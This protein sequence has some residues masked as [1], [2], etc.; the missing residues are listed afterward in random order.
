MTTGLLAALISG[1]TATALLAEEA[2]VFHSWSSEAEVA[3]LNVL[4]EGFEAKGHTWTDVAIPHDTG[5]NVSLLNLVQGGNPPQ[6]FL[7]QAPGF[8]RDLAAMGMAR[9][10][11]DFYAENGYADVLPA[12]VVQS[13]TVDGEIMKIPTAIH[14]AP[15]N[16]S[17]S[18]IAIHAPQSESGC[19]GM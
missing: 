15:F 5:S 18:S 3:A 17:Q 4:R 12:S 14:I 13:V 2:M 6:I 9:P 16:S 11:T 10:L 1:T 8:Y 7:E 19:V